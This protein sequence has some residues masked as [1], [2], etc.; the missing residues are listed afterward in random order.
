MLEVG[1]VEHVKALR[2]AGVVED[3]GVA[4]GS[5]WERGYEVGEAIQDADR[6]VSV[7]DGAATTADDSG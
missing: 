7:D 3:F 1:G 6:F 5:G 2:P 4:S